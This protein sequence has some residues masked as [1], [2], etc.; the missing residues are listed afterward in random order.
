MSLDDLRRKSIAKKI[1]REIHHIN[2][3]ST[4]D[5]ISGSQHISRHTF[6]GLLGWVKNEIST[7]PAKDSYILLPENDMSFATEKQCRELDIYNDQLYSKSLKL[8]SDIT[9]KLAG[10]TLEIKTQ[11]SPPPQPNNVQRLVNYRQ[12][13]KETNCLHQSAAICYLIKLGYVMVTYLDTSLHTINH[14]NNINMFEPYQ[15]IE[16]ADKIASSRKESYLTLGSNLFNNICITDSRPSAPP[17]I[18]PSLDGTTTYDYDTDRRSTAPAKLI[19]IRNSF[20]TNQPRI[21][22]CADTD[23]NTANM[24]C[25]FPEHHNIPD[26]IQYFESNT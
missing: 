19:T 11:P 24:E 12:R 16:I 25:N 18:Y 21:P 8:Y 15:A 9:A 3:T 20:I 6:A 1:S 7:V 17:S 13:N 4:T 26:K 22:T 14:I 2:N 10:S 23:P 5:Q